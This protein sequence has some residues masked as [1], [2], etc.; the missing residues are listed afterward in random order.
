MYT[1]KVIYTRQISKLLG[2][3]PFECVDIPQDPQDTANVTDVIV[4]LY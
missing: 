3:K 4:R 1:S 2:S